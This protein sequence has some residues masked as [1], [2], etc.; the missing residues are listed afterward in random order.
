MIGMNIP[1]STCFQ[2]L[3]QSVRNM[4]RSVLHDVDPL[5]RSEGLPTLEGRSCLCRMDYFGQAL[6]SVDQE[7]LSPTF[8]LGWQLERPIF[9]SSNSFI[10]HN[11]CVV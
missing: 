4:P 9:W 1:L 3:A 2:D 7:R 8:L 6:P 11:F 5:D 10:I